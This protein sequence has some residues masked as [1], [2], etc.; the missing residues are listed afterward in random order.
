M[1]NP[2]TQKGFTIVETLVAITILMIA[3]AGPLSIASKS[4]TAAVTSRDQFVASYLAQESMEAVKN[5]RDNNLFVGNSWLTASPALNACTSG[6][7]C[8]ASAIDSS[9]IQSGKANPLKLTASNYYSHAGSGTNTPFTRYFYL[10][11][12]KPNNGNDCK[13]SDMECVVTVEV[14]WN[15]G[16][17][18]YSIVVNSTIVNEQR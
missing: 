17:V 11:E 7:P 10:A 4:L 14:D 8:D 3:I 12:P 2:T 15:E 5:I 9:P 18:P 16:A 6:N 13:V 1:T